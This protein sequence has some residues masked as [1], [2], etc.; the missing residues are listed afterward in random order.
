MPEHTASI[1]IPA[2]VKVTPCPGK[3]P[4]RKLAS[5]SI[6][7][8]FNMVE[9]ELKRLFKALAMPMEFVSAEADI[10]LE[11]RPMPDGAWQMQITPE[12]ITICAGERTG[13]FTRLRDR[14]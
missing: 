8:E 9:P 6:T 5:V 13:A 7:P 12:K 3:L 10:A 1:L 14:D 4:V 2:P 11:F